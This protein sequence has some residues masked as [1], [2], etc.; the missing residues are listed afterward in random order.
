M[1]PTEDEAPSRPRRVDRRSIATRAK[2]IDAAI[3]QLARHGYENTL[4]AAIATDVGITDAGVMHHYPTKRALFRAVVERIAEFQQGLFRDLLAPGGTEGI[5]NLASLGALIEEVGDYVKATVVVYSEA[6]GD[7][8][9]VREV[10]VAWRAAITGMLVGALEEGVRRGEVAPGVDVGFEA[11]TLL[12]RVNSL[13]VDW[14]FN[15]D[16]ATAATDFATAV[17]VLLARIAAPA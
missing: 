10:I 5:R 7:H 1:T 15:E 14:L 6:M 8:C 2:I 4:I 16:P 13:V 17:D 11:R 9:E 3:G 12:N